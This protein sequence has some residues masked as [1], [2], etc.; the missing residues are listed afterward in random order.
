ME[1]LRQIPKSEIREFS[2]LLEK[3]RLMLVQVAKIF[4]IVRTIVRPHMPE[5]DYLLMEI[6]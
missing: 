6:G 4:G 2:P 5:R 1:W 3:N